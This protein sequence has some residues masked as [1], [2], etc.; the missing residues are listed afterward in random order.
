MS[1]RGSPP[2]S[3]VRTRS[4]GGLY[5]GGPYEKKNGARAHVSG[6]NSG[7]APDARNSNK[8]QQKQNE[9]CPLS[10]HILVTTIMISQTQSC[11]SLDAIAV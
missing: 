3:N 5:V 11:R 1:Y 10:P 4:E 8:K 7:P 6:K 2:R 9:T